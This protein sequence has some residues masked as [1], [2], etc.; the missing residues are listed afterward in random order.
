MAVP[1]LLY[2]YE[3]WPLTRQHERRIETV[4][5]KCLKSAAGHT[6]YA[7]KAN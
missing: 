4:E 1:V 2:G 3:N 7:H 5:F 6:V